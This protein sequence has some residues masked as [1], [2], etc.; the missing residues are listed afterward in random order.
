MI[1]IAEN[2][3]ATSHIIAKALN[4]RDPRPIASIAE[5]ASKAGV[6]YLDV[7]LGHGGQRAKERMEFVL[8]VL[9]DSWSGPLWIDSVDP[10]L[11]KLAA[12]RWHGEVVLNGYAGGGERE[13]VIEL[14][15]SLDLDLVVFLMEK[16]PPATIDERLS[17]AVELI[18]NCVAGGVALE[19][20]IVDPLVAPLGWVDGQERNA[21][22]LKILRALPELF[23]T[24]LRSIIGLSNLLTRSTG[25][26]AVRWLEDVF[27]AMAAGAG[28]THVM[29]DLGNVE[30]LRQAKA[31]TLFTGEGIFAPEQWL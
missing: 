10:D 1:T 26:R 27:L 3:T 9:G 24:P 4:A 13:Q 7:N 31:M 21:D 28:L 16:V 6:D 2:L 8:E 20:I 19:R 30:L 29:L 23:G 11:M 17:L 22:L 14:A 5:A 15:A 18:G 25:Q 12:E